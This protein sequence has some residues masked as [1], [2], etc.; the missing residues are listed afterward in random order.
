MQKIRRL[1]T[2]S[3]IVSAIDDAFGRG[4]FR[5]LVGFSKQQLHNCKTENA[6]PPNTYEVV[7]RH[8]KA[9]S[10]SCE[11]PPSLFKQKEGSIAAA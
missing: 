5:Q 3:Q 2:V 4:A 9:L 8:L 6:L 7:T 10:P 11:A 1:T